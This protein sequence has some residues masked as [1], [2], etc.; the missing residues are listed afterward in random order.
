MQQR[1]LVLPREQWGSLWGPAKLEV[2]AKRQGMRSLRKLKVKVNRE[3]SK[4][5]QDLGVDRGRT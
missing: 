3:K 5:L 4:V 2:S 1:F